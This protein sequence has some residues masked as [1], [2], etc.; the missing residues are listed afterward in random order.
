MQP[1]SVAEQYISLNTTSA[2]S[3]RLALTMLQTALG[4]K[5]IVNRSEPTDAVYTIS[6][7]MAG[8]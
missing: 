4:T 2:A 7:G 5:V 8:L 3:E 1:T 6:C